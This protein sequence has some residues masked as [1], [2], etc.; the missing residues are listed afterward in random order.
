M[1]LCGKSGTDS[2]ES[3]WTGSLGAWLHEGPPGAR[4]GAWQNFSGAAVDWG[5]GAAG[6]GVS[7]R[8][9]WGVVRMLS[10]RGL[11]TPET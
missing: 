3:G 8:A 2:W 1:E 6:G 9:N 11:K 4:K 10:G 5:W 7:S